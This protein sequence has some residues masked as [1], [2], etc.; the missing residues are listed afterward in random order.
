ML[1][2]IRLL[3]PSRRGHLRPST[4]RYTNIEGVDEL[5]PKLAPQ[6]VFQGPEAIA[7]M[8]HASKSFRPFI[9]TDAGLESH[10]YATT[11]MSTNFEHSNCH[12]AVMREGTPSPSSLLPLLK[13]FNEA[14]YDSILGTPTHNSVNP[15]SMGPRCA[16]DNRLFAI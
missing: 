5:W 14:H 13:A 11:M 16:N 12:L 15:Q 3:L 6:R 1:S 10:G 7:K 9:L 8:K 4:R 2:G